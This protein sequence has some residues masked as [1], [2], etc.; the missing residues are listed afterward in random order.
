MGVKLKAYKDMDYHP[1]SEKLVKVLMQKTQNTDPEFFRV[2][3]SFYWALCASMMRCGIKTQDRGELPINLYT[4]ALAPSGYGKG[5]S[6]NVM[7]DVVLDKFRHN[8]TEYVFPV[9]AA[10]HLPK[11]AAQRAARYKTDPDKALEA[12]TNEF[13]KQGPLAFWFDGGSASAIKMQRQLLLMANGGSLNLMID[14]IGSNLTNNIEALT[15]Y[16]ELYDK[17]KIKQK[18]IVNNSDRSRSEE[19][20]GTTPTN[21]LGFGTGAKVLDGSKIEEEFFKM[22]EIGF[23][24]RTIFS[25]AEFHNRVQNLTAEQLFE[26]RVSNATDT[27]L[28]ELSDKV[29]DL[30][31][32]AQ[33]NKMLHV[34]KD[35]S[36]IFIAYQLEC[37]DNADKLGIH[38]ETQKAEMSHRHFKALKLAGAY[39]F[40][41]GL[42]EITEDHAYYAI[43]LCEDSGKAFEKI[44]N[45]DGVHVKL[46]KYIASVKRPVTQVELVDNLPYYKGSAPQRNEFMTLAIAYGYQNNIIIKKTYENDVEFLTG[47]TLAATDLGALRVSYSG[48]IAN[49]YKNDLG[50]WEDLH[51][52]TQAQ[53]IHW[54]NHHFVDGENSMGNRKEDNAIAG[55][56]MIVL[57]IDDG[58]PLHQARELLAE[59]KALFYT[60]RHHQVD[61]NGKVCDRYRILLPTNYV[62]E[63]DHKDHKEFMKAVYDWLPFPV[64][65]QTGQRARKWLSNAGQHFY[66]DGELFD[67][68]PFIPKTTK[69]EEFKKKLIDQQGMDNLERWVLNNSGTG[70]RN[71]MLMR[72]AMVLVDSSMDF[73]TI[74]QKVL[75]LNSKWGDSLDENEI[76]GTVMVTV[77]KALT[78]HAA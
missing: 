58:V 25:Y 23:G 71:S 49:N 42:S 72:Y 31:D 65:D 60:T 17:G 5:Y 56:N 6:T 18:L 4:I 30:A 40:I 14:E 77:S 13:E 29:E 32:P 2:I 11:I 8:F 7:E 3:V 59:Y 75:T 53:G 70:N 41:D 44:V 63:L 55:F 22:Q 26:D 1:I 15:T 67:V 43:K 57:D 51:A 48:D 20:P 45:R 76:M 74:R 64:D 78:K 35:V 50:K 27:F 47:E 16:L 28:D 21:F 69:N 39:A 34:S 66:Q 54:C 46:A 52:L 36:L 38:Q 73:E 62:L 37:E 9:L 61:K 12:V 19:I 68:L 24:R 10:K 33:V